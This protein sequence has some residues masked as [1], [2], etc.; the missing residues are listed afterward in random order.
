[1]IVAHIQ[2][3]K[4]QQMILV[5]YMIAGT[6]YMQVLQ[7]PLSLPKYR[8]GRI[9]SVDYRSD[10]PGQAVINFLDYPRIRND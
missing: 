7:R 9:V 6:Y 4:E 5:Q 10:N 3:E 2:G 8:I 1:M